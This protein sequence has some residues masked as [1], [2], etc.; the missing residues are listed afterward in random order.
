MRTSWNVG[1]ATD[2]A[3][4]VPRATPRTK[5]VFPAPSSP[6]S[7]TRSPLRR[8][9][10]SSSPAASVSSAAEVSRKVVVAEV[11][12]L[13]R[14]AVYTEHL[15]RRVVGEIPEW[16]QS[17][18]ADGILRPDADQLRL[19]AACQSLLQR[20]TIR[21][22]HLTGADHGTRARKGDELV[23][24]AQEAVGDVTAAEP[25]RVQLAT[26]DEQRLQ[27][28]RA[29]LAKGDRSGPEGTGDR[30]RPA[31]ASFAPRQRTRISSS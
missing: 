18:A 2:A 1:L 8:R 11:L 12:D 22:R 23:H 13:Q 29:A 24:L 27:S 7:R 19:L 21:D 30:H 10:P 14:G 6:L 20:C 9:R 15:D 28:K 17:G 26:F 16:P 3:E 4:P 31:S 25:C 5:V